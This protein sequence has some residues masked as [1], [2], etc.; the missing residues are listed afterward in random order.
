[1]M[2]FLMVILKRHQFCLADGSCKLVMKRKKKK[3]NPTTEATY[4][5]LF[6]QEEN[7]C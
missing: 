7:A 6:N 2:T 1:M 3:Q 4:I 5:L